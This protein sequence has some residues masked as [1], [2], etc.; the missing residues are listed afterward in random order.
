M[1][2][3]TDSQ[4]AKLA[5]RL[6]RSRGGQDR[7]EA[8]PDVLAALSIP[9]RG[10]RESA[11]VKA[12]AH[13]RVLLPVYPHAPRSEETNSDLVS[14]DIGSGRRA[15]AMFS[16]LAE[17][18][19]T[20]PDARPVPVRARKLAL[21]ALAGPA[22]M[23]LDGTHVVSRPATAAL[24]QGDTWLPAWEDSDLVAKVSELVADIGIERVGIQAGPAGTSRVLLVLAGDRGLSPRSVIEAAGRRLRTCERLVVAC[25]RIELVPL[26]EHAF[27]ESGCE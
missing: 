24:A 17:L 6:S 7:G 11:L 21:N 19:R 18:T 14:V 16:S 9:E 23:L 13:A 25:D 12:L 2:A 22:R 5:Q 10:P 26:A 27:A 15:V 3:L 8:D 20:Y 4:R 1:N